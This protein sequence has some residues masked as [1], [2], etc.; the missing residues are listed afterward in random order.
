MKRAYVFTTAM[1]LCFFMLE[2]SGI[3]GSANIDEAWVCYLKSDFGRA[4]EICG[5]LPRTKALEARGLYLEGLCFLKLGRPANAR[6]SFEKALSDYPNTKLKQGLLVG[7][8]DSYFSEGNFEKALQSYYYLLKK[9]P[10]SDY[11]SIAYLKMG[12][13]LRRQG[14]WQEAEGSF[15]RVIKGYPLSLEF[16]QA[17]TLRNKGRF[18]TIQAGAFLKQANALEFI[19]ELKAKGYSPFLEKD[20]RQGKTYY[21]V[22][23]GRFPA[24]KSVSEQCDRLKQDGIIPSIIS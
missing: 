24:L 18:F 15:D 17:K 2:I 13:S 11:A 5:S 22:I 20:S 9:F 14:K 16:E 23:I 3:C 4:I 10:E 7:I 12:I 8:A 6:Q 1:V 21:K 19:K